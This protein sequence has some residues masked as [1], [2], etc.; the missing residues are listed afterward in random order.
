LVKCSGRLSGNVPLTAF[1]TA[2]LLGGVRRVPANQRAPSRIR[3]TPNRRA[4]A[5]PFAGRIE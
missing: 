5:A 4:G 2:V 1:M 3:E